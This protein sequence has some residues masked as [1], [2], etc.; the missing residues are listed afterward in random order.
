M[1]RYFFHLRNDVDAPDREGVQLTSLDAAEQF[2]LRT[3]RFNAAETIKDEGRF[4][5]DHCIDIEDE[6]DTVL[7][8]IYFRDAVAIEA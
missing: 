1:P 4:V 8:T 5:G 6:D 3:A 7:E 2:A